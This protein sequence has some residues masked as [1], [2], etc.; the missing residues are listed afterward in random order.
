[1]LAANR[2][3]RVL[4]VEDNPTD[5]RLV[6]EALS[7]HQVP[8]EMVVLRDGEEALEYLEHM[9]DKSKPDLIILDLNL[10]KRD[11]FGVL[12]EYR[13]RPALSFVPIVILTSSDSPA[14]KLRAKSIGVAAFLQK[15]MTL[16]EFIALGPRFRAILQG[17]DIYPP[18]L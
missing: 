1:M 17:D 5:A 2:T 18:G 16:E 12:N 8:H 13:A 11:G 6:E 10:P 14:D 7:E 9:A 15:P 4:V 3:Y